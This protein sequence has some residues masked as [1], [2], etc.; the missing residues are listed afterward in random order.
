M[1]AATKEL[2]GFA[3]DSVYAEYTKTERR[4]ADRVEEESNDRRAGVLA[5]ADANAHHTV[6]GCTDGGLRSLLKTYRRELEDIEDGDLPDDKSRPRER[7]AKAKIADIE[8]EQEFRAVL[9][10]TWQAAEDG[11]HSFTGF[12]ARGHLTG[13]IHHGATPPSYDLAQKLDWRNWKQGL[14]HVLE[15]SETA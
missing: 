15:W 2:A 6:R 5:L 10:E 14:P 8:R 9:A 11:T 4:I 13:V 3:P 12:M 1:G 7:L